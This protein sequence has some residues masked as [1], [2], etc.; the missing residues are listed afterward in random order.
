[1]RYRGREEEGGIWQDRWLYVECRGERR[2][3][4]ALM[5]EVEWGIGACASLRY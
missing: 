4:R 3:V 2:Q 1:M 5:A